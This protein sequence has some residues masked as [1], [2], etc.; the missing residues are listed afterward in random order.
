MRIL[1]VDDEPNL[2]RLYRREFREQ[3]FEVTL[4]RDALEALHL[5]QANPPDCIVIDIATNQVKNLFKLARWLD[6]DPSIPVIIH[7]TTL[8]YQFGYM[9]HCAQGFVLKPSDLT[10]LSSTI[11]KALSLK[12][13][14]GGRVG[15]KRIREAV[16]LFLD[17]KSLAATP[18][19]LQSD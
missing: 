12:K 6:R 2:L 19:L 14:Q 11:R 15:I 1:F 10:L 5:S 9:R 3:G 17:Q 13:R 7:T 18:T 16:R 4:A 8:E